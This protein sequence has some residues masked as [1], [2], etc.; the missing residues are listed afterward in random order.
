MFVLR[1][2]PVFISDRFFSQELGSG[3]LDKDLYLVVQVVRVGRLIYT[4]SSKKPLNQTY[5]RPH[6]VAVHNLKEVLQSRVEAAGSAWSPDC[7][8]EFLLKLYQS[9]EKDFGL[10]HEIVAKKSSKFSPLSGQASV[11]VCLQ[12]LHGQLSALR[13]EFIHILKNAPLIKKLGFP[14]VI[15]PGDVRYGNGINGTKRKSM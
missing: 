7:E 15:M 10:W 5:R 9:E 8:R 6:A 13:H 14:D 11:V 1:C 12:W 3:D 2:L 4:E